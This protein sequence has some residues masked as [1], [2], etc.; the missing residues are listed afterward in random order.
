MVN[1]IT[2]KLTYEDIYDLKKKSLVK[3]NHKYTYKGVLYQVTDLVFN[4]RTRVMDVVYRPINDQKL[5]PEFS[6]PEKDFLNKFKN[7]G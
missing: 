1:K 6:R 2:G 7:Y 4:T 5:N 3:I